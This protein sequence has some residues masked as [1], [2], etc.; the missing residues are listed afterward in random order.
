[1]PPPRW[2]CVALPHRPE[3]PIGLPGA[4][5]GFILI[6]QI[7]GKQILLASDLLEMPVRCEYWES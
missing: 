5:Y 2:Q 3:K 4:I 7:I 1:M 6:G